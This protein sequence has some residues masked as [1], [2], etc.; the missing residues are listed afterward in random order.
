MGPILQL[1]NE[2][3]SGFSELDFMVLAGTSIIQAALEPLPFSLAE[4]HLSPFSS[5]QTNPLWESALPV[6]VTY[7]QLPKIVLWMEQSLQC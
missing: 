3:V 1:G 4:Y 5:L 7:W 2:L 6:T